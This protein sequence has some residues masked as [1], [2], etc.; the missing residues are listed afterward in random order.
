M[1]FFPH[2][3]PFISKMKAKKKKSYSGN[4]TTPLCWIHISSFRT[5][6]WHVVVHFTSFFSSLSM[7]VIAGFATRNAI[8]IEWKWIISCTL[9]WMGTGG[10]FGFVFR[11]FFFRRVAQ[12]GIVLASSQCI[13]YHLG[14]LQRFWAAI[15]ACFYYLLCFDW[16][17][18][19]WMI[20]LYFVLNVCLIC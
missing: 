13:C 11:G 20:I 3:S 14:W 4:H 5:H 7:A 8:S 18:G 16:P 6:K 19:M 12:L 9:G 2:Q 17:G 10:T 1:P 15:V